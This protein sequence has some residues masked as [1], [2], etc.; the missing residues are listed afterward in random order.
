VWQIVARDGK[1]VEKPFASYSL[2]KAS[3]R[4]A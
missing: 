1:G 2:H 4:A 3:C